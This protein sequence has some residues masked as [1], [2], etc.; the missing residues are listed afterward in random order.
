MRILVT[1]DYGEL[2]RTAAEIVI[3]AVKSKPA[4]N[5]GLPTGNTPRGMYDELARAYREGRADFSDL[6]TFNLDEYSGLPPD[7]PH[8]FDAYMREHFFNHVNVRQENIHFPD[9]S[10]DYEQQI[11]EAGGIDLLIVGIGANGH[12]AFNEPGASVSSRTRQ[13]ELAPETIAS[14]RKDFSPDPVPTHA[15]TIGIATILDCRRIVL[16]A[17]GK[18]KADIVQQALHGPISESVPASALQKHP[19]LIALLDAG[20]AFSQ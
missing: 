20:A 3:Q 6:H 13:V 10:R 8:R 19:N 18:P 16:M 15:I 7:D 17:S 5:L 2:S 14:A 1:P 9:V 12:I 11:T 4:L